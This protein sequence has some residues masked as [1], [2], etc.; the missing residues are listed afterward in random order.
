MRKKLATNDNN[1]LKNNKQIN[2]SYESMNNVGNTQF[3]NYDGNL[4]QFD[5][6]SNFKEESKIND[7]NMYEKYRIPSHIKNTQLLYGHGDK[8]YEFGSERIIEKQIKGTD[9]KLLN[10]SVQREAPKQSYLK[11]SQTKQHGLNFRDIMQPEIVLSGFQNKTTGS[12]LNELSNMIEQQ[13]TKQNNLEITMANLKVDENYGLDHKSIDSFGSF[14]KRNDNEQPVSNFSS[15]SNNNPTDNKNEKNFAET[16]G[17][18]PNRIS[19]HLLS[20]W[21][22]PIN[23]GLTE[24]KLFDKNLKDILISEENLELTNK[25]TTVSNTSLKKLVNNKVGTIHPSDMYQLTYSATRDRYRIDINLPFNVKAAYIVIWN[26]NEETNKGVRFMKI[27]HKTKLVF[28][29]EL[30]QANGRLSNCGKCLTVKFQKNLDDSKLIALLKKR[31]GASKLP[32]PLIKPGNIPASDNKTINSVNSKDVRQSQYEM[33]TPKNQIKLNNDQVNTLRKSNSIRK[34][35]KRM[36]RLDTLTRNTNTNTQSS[37]KMN[38]LKYTEPKSN[39]KS[40]KSRYSKLEAVA[41]N[42][43]RKSLSS[44]FIKKAHLSSYKNHHIPELPKVSGINIQLLSNWDDKAYIGLCGLEI[45]DYKGT[46]LSLSLDMVSLIYKKNKSTYKPGSEE[47]LLDNELITCDAKKHWMHPFEA[48]T[49]VV[50]R[51]KFKNLL[52]LSLIRLWNYNCSRIHASKGVKECIISDYENKLLLFAGK[53]R[54]AT[55]S[56]TKPLKNCESV[57]FT[58]NKNILMD[59]AKNDWFYVSQNGKGNLNIKKNIKNCFEE[60]INERPTTSEYTDDNFH[61]QSMPKSRFKEAGLPRIDEYNSVHSAYNTNKV[62][63]EALTVLKNIKF[64]ILTTWGNEKE[65]GL[66]GIDF[67]GSKKEKLAHDEYLITSKNRLAQYNIVDV[68]SELKAKR[69]VF[70]EFEKM[71]E[72]ILEINFKSSVTL[73]SIDFYGIENLKENVNKSIKKILIYID[74]MEITNGVGLFLKKSC[75]YEFYTHKPQKITFPIN[76]NVVNIEQ[77][78][79]SIMPISQPT[80]FILEFHL[81]NT[82]GDPYYIGLNGLE[83]FDLNGTNILSNRNQENFTMIAEPPG[84]FILPELSKDTRVVANLHKPKP[85]RDNLNDIWLTPFTKYDKL[86][87]QNVIIVEFTKPVAIGLIN[88]WNYS[89]TLNRAVKEVDI[90]LDGNIIYSGWLNDVNERLLSSI[91]FSDSIVNQRK[92]N[93]HIERIKHLPKEIT[94][95]YCEG[96]ILKRKKSDKYLNEFRPTT[97]AHFFN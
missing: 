57:I 28:E 36:E 55:G 52:K 27:Y 8:G 34:S 77:N 79:S 44:P 40:Q 91:I 63:K 70:F 15:F 18:K 24:I 84:V 78:P 93:I 23:I 58:T 86:H 95:L 17:Q 74:D 3:D 61:R 53:I 42:S 75:K 62:E 21:G 5:S 16:F 30:M 66:S 4:E 64:V 41:V 35:P 76:Q 43:T 59:L 31:Y 97:G 80:G 12:P 25:N 92:E 32:I 50:I 65:F 88:I 51:I 26:F 82:F 67:Y 10:S 37:K 60:F 1:K 89:R 56:L 13:N 71:A 49:S 7:Y 14:G 33:S 73:T 54:K 6:F 39:S 48:N 29:G 83:I 9:K 19:I 68:D 11:Y 85:Y 72:N 94:E 47:R 69:H 20:N 45:F 87:N 22:S 38:P 2:G 90:Y 96:R 46:K 81:K